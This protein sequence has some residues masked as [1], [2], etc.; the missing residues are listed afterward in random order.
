ME[1]EEKST[2]KVYCVATYTLP[3]QAASARKSC[4]PW[5]ALR[6]FGSEGEHGKQVNPLMPKL[7]A[8]V[9]KLQILEGSAS[10][11]CPRRAEQRAPLAFEACPLPSLRGPAWPDLSMPKQSARKLRQPT[12]CTRSSDIHLA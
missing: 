2:M 8:S 5:S 11:A 7:E 12:L 10:S 6:P 9:H 1:Q 3:G 4:L